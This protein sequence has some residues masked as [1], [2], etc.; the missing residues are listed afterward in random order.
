MCCRARIFGS[1]SEPRAFIYGRPAP[2]LR[3]L[4]LLLLFPCPVKQNPKTSPGQSAVNAREHSA[5]E[6]T[7]SAKAAGVCARV[8][9]IRFGCALHLPVIPRNLLRRWKGEKP[10]EFGSWSSSEFLIA[11]FLVCGDHKRTKRKLVIRLL[12]TTGGNTFQ[13]LAAKELGSFE[14][15]ALSLWEKSLARFIE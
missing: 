4:L 13:E 2:R 6:G 10:P 5:N 14:M 12:G 1:S 9:P 3:L 8:G 15:C 7:G 11:N